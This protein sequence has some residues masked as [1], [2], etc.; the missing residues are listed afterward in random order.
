MEILKPN[1]RIVN[2]LTNPNLKSN[3]FNKNSIKLLTFKSKKVI[4]QVIMAN[5]EKPEV[6]FRQMAWV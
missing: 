6:L 5:G 3:I 2:N 4:S 1:L